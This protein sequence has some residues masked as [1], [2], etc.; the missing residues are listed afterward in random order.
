MTIL[1][2]DMDGVLCDFEHAAKQVL[3]KSIEADPTTEKAK[4]DHAIIRQVPNFWST[5]PWTDDGK[6]LW[7][8]VKVYEAHILS[9]YANWDLRSA[10]EKLT[11]IHNH[12]GTLPKD[13]I[14]IVQRKEKQDYATA[15]SG[16]PNVLVDDWEKN[17][18]EWKHAGG[19]PIHH[20]GA[21]SSI[22]K[23]E[24]LGFKKS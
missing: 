11:W 21:R 17:V 13:R 5:L 7:N 19:I 8:Y 23:L 12:L 24:R 18:I 22:T 1:F 6:Q 9:A 20:V 3:G 2:I 14:H 10:Q 4:K 15:I 16:K